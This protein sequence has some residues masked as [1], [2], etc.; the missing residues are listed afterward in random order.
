ML[1]LAEEL[2]SSDDGF[3]PERLLPSGATIVWVP[4]LGRLARAAPDLGD[5]FARRRD[6]VQATVVAVVRTGDEKLV[7]QVGLDGGAV[8]V[9]MSGQLTP[10]EQENARRMFGREMSTIGDVVR[11]SLPRRA[12]QAAYLAASYD[13]FGRLTTENDALDITPDVQMLASLVGSRQ[14]QPPLSI[15][16][17]GP[18]G[19]GKSFLMHQVKLGAV[20]LAKRSRELGPGEV[21]AY[22]PKL[23]TV[24]FNAWQYVHGVDLWASLVSRVFEGIRDQLDSTETYQKLWQDIRESSS[25][26][27]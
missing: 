26:V 4:N 25:H 23:V 20:D 14:V 12:G 18:W 11:A 2:A 6:A 16:L 9:Q 24:D 1:L 8:T 15:G 19:S 21:S 13:A 7:Q 5:W 17:F 22:C 27:A 10:G 3:D